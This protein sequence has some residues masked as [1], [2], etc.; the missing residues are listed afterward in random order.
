ME[1]TWPSVIDALGGTDAVAG[2]LSQA[3]STV[4]GWRKRGIPSPHWAAVVKLA[5]E[6]GQDD[7]TLEVL[8]TLSARKAEKSSDCCEARA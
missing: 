3:K 4:S 6:L 2:S 8:A 1:W 5:A 7:L